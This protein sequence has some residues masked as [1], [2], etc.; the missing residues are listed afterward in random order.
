MVIELALIILIIIM[1]FT[2]F[3]KYTNF[4]GLMPYNNDYEIQ[5]DCYY[6]VD[7]FSEDNL[8]GRVIDE[9]KRLRYWGKLCPNKNY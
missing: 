9:K 1:A 5:Q 6:D 7:A 3:L 8:Y 2:E 4:L